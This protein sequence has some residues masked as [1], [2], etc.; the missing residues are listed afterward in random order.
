[1][2]DGRI[3]GY[4]NTKYLAILQIEQILDN[5]DCQFFKART[6]QLMRL[7]YELFFATPCKHLHILVL[8][9]E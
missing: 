7:I 4:F 6:G 2:T 1:M 9:W 8:G 5:F 3:S